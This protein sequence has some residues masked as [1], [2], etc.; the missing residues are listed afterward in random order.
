MKT[1]RKSLAL[2]LALVLLLTACSPSGGNKNAASSSEDKQA[3]SGKDELVF[4][5]RDIN[6]TLD[7]TKPQSDGYLRRVGALEALFWAQNDGTVVPK[8]A[9]SGKQL[10]ENTWEIKLRENAK[11]WSG[12]P[13]TADVVIASFNRSKELN[14]SY[15][16]ALKGL[17]FEAKDDYTLLVTTEEKNVDVPL[18][19]ISISVSNPEMDYTS[20]DQID[21]TGMYKVTEFNPKQSLKLTRND[22]YYGEKPKIKNILFEEILDDDARL[23]AALSGRADIVSDIPATGGPKIEASKDMDLITSNPS[24]TLSV[25]LNMQRKPLDDVRVRQALNWGTDRKELVQLH[26]G[27]YGMPVSTWLGSNPEYPETK[28]AV[29][30]NYD[31]EKASSLLDAAGWTMGSDNIRHKDGKDLTFKLYTWGSE[32]ILGEA[33]Q[34][35]WA[36]L[37]IKVDLNYVDYSVVE[38]ARETGDW[39]GLIETWTHFG[40]M[41]AIIDNHFGP[42][43]SLNY[44]KYR[45]EKLDKLLADLSKA[46]D[47]DE[48]HRLSVDVN[49]LVAEE[50]VLVPMMPRPTLIA[51]KKNLKGFEI[52]F[53]QHEN[54]ITNKLEFVEE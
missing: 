12:K 8:L 35:Q 34:N 28:D 54:Y 32:K 26:T 1:L 6:S 45:S 14:S 27:G 21:F 13:V 22:D 48:I 20:V 42:N 51:I 17:S 39:D 46:T 15:A 31:F 40:Y 7:P 18:N 50:G 5:A 44:G 25:F 4:I 10:D 53:I 30:P 47:K 19:L 36:K 43:G 29:Y 49:T 24:G 37:G 11:F 2:L 9:E 16:S 23:M 3:G 38:Q 52:H 41:Y 33:L